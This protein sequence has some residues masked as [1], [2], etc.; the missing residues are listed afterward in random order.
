MAAR[1]PY[2][3]LFGSQDEGLGL[4]ASL[5]TGVALP[6]IR[7][8]GEPQTSTPSVLPATTPAVLPTT[9]KT[10]T[11]PAD[12][13]DWYWNLGSGATDPTEKAV[14]SAVGG[15]GFDP[16]QGL[17]PNV[18]A[19]F[20]KLF[21]GATVGRASSGVLDVP[22]LGMLDVIRNYG[23]PGA[24]WWSGL[25]SPAPTG[26][27]TPPSTATAPAGFDLGGL[28]GLVGAGE[29][30]AGPGEPG[31]F[32]DSAQTPET[33]E[34]TPVQQVGQDPLS[35]LLSGGLVGLID[36]LS[37]PGAAESLLLER[38]QSD[39]MPADI[40]NRRMESAREAAERVR[41]SELD[42]LRSQLADRNLISVPGAPQGSERTG[43]ERISESIAGQQFGVLRD[44]GSA[45]MEQYGT[46]TIASLVAASQAGS[47]RARTILD[48]LIAGTERQA[49]LSYIALANLRENREW[50]QFLAQYG[51]D[52]DQILEDLQMGRLQ[53]VL[54]ILQA[55]MN[56]TQI[57]T[58]GYI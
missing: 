33:F 23:D 35:L 12:N 27:Q 37:G 31:V 43:L 19:E 7:A 25:E 24:Q 46:E 9:P 1:R 15:K 36:A 48:T 28:P 58:Q 39:T 10:A 20:A 29:T 45:L 21:P 53:N 34:D 41:T 47:E 14:W 30:Y 5:D 2:S 42:T 54:P 38:G 51:M 3:G 4:D 55:F 44:V 57:S 13:P 32:Q 56:A 8:L 22:G 52:R 11:A 16:T 26:A 18:M 17:T 40:L 50:N 49:T 6:D